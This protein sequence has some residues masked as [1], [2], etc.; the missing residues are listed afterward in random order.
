MDSGTGV[1]DDRAGPGDGRGGGNYPPPQ[2]Q[3]GGAQDPRMMDRTDSRMS[4]GLIVSYLFYY[5]NA[6]RVFAPLNGSIFQVG[7]IKNP[8][9][10]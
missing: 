7:M 3:G 2:Q 9:F 4:G 1:Y 10:R 6:Q 5:A 8:Q